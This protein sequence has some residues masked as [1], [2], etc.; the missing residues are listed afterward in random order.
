[1]QLRFRILLPLCACLLVTAC[2]TTSHR[3]ERPAGYSFEPANQ[4][5]RSHPLARSITYTCEDTST[6]TLTEGENTALVAFNSGTQM[7][8]SRRG[9][10]YGQRPYE[11]MR[12]GDEGQL[13]SN[14]R[15]FRCRV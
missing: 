8:L 6:V 15:A 7:R 4:P 9:D 1:M 12:R 3:R 10:H 13:N 2:E 14:G 5:S 11:F